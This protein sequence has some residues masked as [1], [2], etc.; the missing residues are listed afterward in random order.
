MESQEQQDQQGHVVPRVQEVQEGAV[1]HQVHQ[2][3][4]VPLG[5]WGQK[6]EEAFLVAQGLEEPLDMPGT[7]ARLQTSK[8]QQ[9]LGDQQADQVA[10]LDNADLQATQVQQANQAD[11][12]LLGEEDQADLQVNFSCPPA[13]LFFYTG[14]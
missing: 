3:Q 5:Q 10:P 1:V 9:E 2:G 11:Q 7:G 14:H 13:P 12:G 6:A 8:V 4:E